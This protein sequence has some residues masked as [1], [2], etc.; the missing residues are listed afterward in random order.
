MAKLIQSIALLF[1][2]VLTGCDHHQK[3]YI[4]P[5]NKQVR[6][7]IASCHT[8]HQYDDNQCHQ[9]RKHCT[10]ERPTLHPT[11]PN[12]RIINQHKTSRKWKTSEFVIETTDDYCEKQ[13]EVC[14]KTN[15]ENYDMCFT[16]CGGIIR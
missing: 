3:H 1:I 10:I 12:H 2:T 7:C 4:I 11:K 13:K 9:T 6:E 5:E 8:N 16:T 14:I 15:R